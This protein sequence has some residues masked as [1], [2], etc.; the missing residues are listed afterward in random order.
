MFFG[1]NSS[2]IGHTQ[3]ALAAKVASL[4]LC[5]LFVAEK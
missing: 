1:A 3:T 4:F 2:G 5:L